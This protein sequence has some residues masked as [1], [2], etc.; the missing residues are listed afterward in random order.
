MGP[1]VAPLMGKGAPNLQRLTILNISALV[2][3][4]LGDIYSAGELAKVTVL[5]LWKPTLVGSHMRAWMDGVLASEHRG[6]A[7]ESLHFYSAAERVRMLAR[8]LRC[9]SRPS[10]R[11]LSRTYEI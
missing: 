10:A 4:Q 7:L 9:S 8:P 2:L 3:Q 11:A 1:L 5:H 6:A